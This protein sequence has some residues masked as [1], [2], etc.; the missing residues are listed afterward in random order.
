[1]IMVVVEGSPLVAILAKRRAFM[2]DLWS[3]GCIIPTFIYDELK[4]MSQIVLCK[5]C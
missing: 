1:M 5:L 3:S 4:I 2:V